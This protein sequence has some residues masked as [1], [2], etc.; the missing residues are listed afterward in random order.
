MANV[1]RHKRGTSV[2]SASDFSGTGELLVRTDT[3]IVYTKKDDGTV[4][5]I[6]GG[7]SSNL[8]G[9]SDVTLTNPS[10]GQVLKYN[11]T[12]WINDA[13]ATGGSTDPYSSNL[14]SLSSNQT[15][16]AST[17]AAVFGPSYTVASGVTLTISTGSFFS[18]L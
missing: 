4:V 5:G 2:P 10:N 1:I 7:G 16:P 6:S 9:L 18:V 8:S 12:A 13:D 15:I 11:G 17:N 3:G 14:Q